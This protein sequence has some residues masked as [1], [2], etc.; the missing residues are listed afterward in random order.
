MHANRW[1]ANR[2]VLF[3]RP[4]LELFL[5]ERKIPGGFPER[6]HCCRV[7]YLVFPL[8][9]AGVGL[10]HN[11]NVTLSGTAGGVAPR[12]PPPE[13]PL[14]GW[15]LRGASQGPGAL[16]GSPTEGARSSQAAPFWP[17]DGPRGGAT[18]SR[19]ILA[20]QAPATSM[21]DS[22]LLPRRGPSRS[23]WLRARKARPQLILSRRPRRRL[24]AL[25]WCGRRRLRRRLLQTQAAGADW[26]EG[27]C[28]ASRAAAA[29]RP[30]TAAPNPASSPTP[31]PAPAAD[32]DSSYLATLPIPPVRP[33]GPGRALVLLPLEQVGGMGPGGQREVQ[34]RGRPWSLLPVLWSQ[35][36]RIPRV[37][38]AEP[39]I[40]R[41]LLRGFL[42]LQS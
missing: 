23:T 35:V 29:R 34:A 21:A 11:V 39:R 8:E 30:K 38:D 32:P 15:S 4:I 22:P 17:L 18:G 7:G 16:P 25:R 36:G 42:G 31:S 12:R 2:P 13:R 27:G 3:K 14:A 26:R 6:W 41:T 1:Y 5:Q 19:E 10:L 28:L 9:V 24:G 37:G 33:A 40:T 20:R